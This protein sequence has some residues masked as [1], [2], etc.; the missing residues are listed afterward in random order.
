M[1]IAIAMSM[2]VAIAMARCTTTAMVN[3][4]LA[5]GKLRQTYG[6]LW[7]TTAFSCFCCFCCVCDQVNQAAPAQQNDDIDE[8]H[9]LDPANQVDHKDELAGHGSQLPLLF[10]LC[11]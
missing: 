11:V 5:S 1:T 8:G 4:W 10:L 9:Q 3:Q 7:L 6:G 2:A